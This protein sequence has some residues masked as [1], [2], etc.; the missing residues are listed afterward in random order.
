[1]QK[2]YNRIYWENFPSE[3]TAVNESNLNNMDLGL[4]ELD[5]RVIKVDAAKT[6]ITTSNTLV[7]E[8]T[9]DEST[10]IITV[11]KLNGDQL[12]FDLNIE[13]I[14]VSFELSEDGILTM[15]TDDGTK[16]TANIGAM[17][18]ILTFDSTDTIAVATSGEGINKTYAF[19]VKN[20]SITEEKLQTNYLADIK[21]E[22]ANAQ[23]YAQSASASSVQS[24]NS[25][26]ESKSYAVGGTGTREGEDTDNAKYYANFAKTKA[27]SADV[28]AQNASASEVNAKASETNA[29]TSETNSKTSETN[30]KNSETNAATSETNA[31]ESETNSKT[32]ET[33]ASS[34]ADTSK[35][36]AVG[37]NNEVRE[38][39]ANDN[40]KRYSE[41]AKEQAETA[42]TSAENAKNSMAEIIK[43][44]N[45]TEFEVDFTTGELMQKNENGFIFNINTTSGNLEWEVA[46]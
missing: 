15:T 12:T 3:K 24:E 31:K 46:V 37:T 19:S 9:M 2:I 43:Q 13:K 22:V 30:A 18:P 25:A 45:A 29:K 4:D 35:S 27:D 36:Y 1:M 17:I 20:G 26:Q 16:F 23:A 42:K 21:V 41:V 7:K 33:N 38:G 11:T 40:A 28:S 39:D 10:G 44:L 8:W 6:D 32:S 34:Y 14:P 5:N